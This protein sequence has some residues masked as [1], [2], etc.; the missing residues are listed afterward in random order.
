VSICAIFLGKKKVII[1]L[2][3]FVEAL[4]LAAVPVAQ[5]VRPRCEIVGQLVPTEI[6]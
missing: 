2:G 1:L 5:Q 3:S 6:K 4:D